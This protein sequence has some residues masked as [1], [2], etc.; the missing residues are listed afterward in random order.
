MLRRLGAWALLAVIAV[1]CGGGPST[2]DKLAVETAYLHSWDTYADAV[3]RLDTS[4]LEQSFIDPILT[5]TRK[6]IERRIQQQCPSSVSIEHHI[7]ITSLHSTTAELFDDELNH[8]VLLDP[9]TR[10]PK[11]ADPNQK[12]RDRVTMQKIGGVW[13]VASIAPAKT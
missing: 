10:A 8:S 11:E 6:E 9:A 2:Q 13:M 3:L 7:T 1:A 5:T 12:Q 4:Q